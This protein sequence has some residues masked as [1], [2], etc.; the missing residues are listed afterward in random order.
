MFD[1][2]AALFDVQVAVFE[3]SGLFTYTNYAKKPERAQARSGF[4]YIH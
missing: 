3:A 2:Q 4:L 1:V